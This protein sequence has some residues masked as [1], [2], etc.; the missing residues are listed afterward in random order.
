MKK[1]KRKPN[2]SMVIDV[3]CLGLVLFAFLYDFYEKAKVEKDNG[4]QWAGLI[5]SLILTV[6]TI[7]SIVFSLGKETY[8]GI[9]ISKYNR[10]R[11]KGYF[12]FFH[13]CIAVI[14]VVSLSGLFSGLMQGWL[15]REFLY[16]ALSLSVCSIIYSIVFIFEEVPLLIRN[17]NAIK[18]TIEHAYK[19]SAMSDNLDSK[20][21]NSILDTVLLNISLTEGIQTAYDMIAD[22]NDDKSAL[23]HLLELEFDEY[24]QINNAV[25]EN[26][27][28]LFEDSYF[29]D[30]KKGADL[31]S[32]GYKNIQD[33]ITNMRFENIIKNEK[34]N[35]IAYLAYELIELH[36]IAEITKQTEAERRGL[37]DIIGYE[38]VL[39]KPLLS[40]IVYACALTCKEGKTWFV[41]Y[42][43]MNNHLDMLLYREEGHYLGF[44]LAMMIVFYS[45]AYRGTEKDIYDLL[46]WDDDKKTYSI[47]SGVA[48]YLDDRELDE[49]ELLEKIYYLFN[50]VPPQVFIPDFGVCGYTSTN[51]FSFDVIINYWLEIIFRHSFYHWSKDDV[52]TSLEKYDS[53]LQENIYHVLKETW[54]NDNKLADSIPAYFIFSIC[55]VNFEIKQTPGNKGLINDL[56]A[57]TDKISKEKDKEIAQEPEKPSNITDALSYLKNGFKNK[58]ASVMVQDDS[59]S[60][61]KRHSISITGYCPKQ[62]YSIYFDLLFDRISDDIVAEINKEIKKAVSPIKIENIVS[63]DKGTLNRIKKFEPEFT[64]SPYE[65]IPIKDGLKNEVKTYSNGLLFVT[66]WKEDGIRLK[67]ELTQASIKELTDSEAEQF[68]RDHYQTYPNGFY[69]YVNN[70]YNYYVTMDELKEKIKKQYW[71]S[72]LSY[73]WNVIVNKENCLRFEKKQ[74]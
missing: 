61:K 41:K 16:T 52:L 58:M 9:T 57:F 63:Y 33:V 5:T 35:D 54:L 47:R 8:Y 48:A 69:R 17:E 62:D 29:I 66:F 49:F 34:G 68:I 51:E 18:R 27:S 21:D 7:V 20:R 46:D 1:Q 36:E 64:T 14:I 28:L 74:A 43:L 70:G 10:I 13:K 31:I 73:R 4:F 44:F 60:L 23:E 40:L 59:M 26:Q 24:K 71:L 12:D 42:L 39:S 50:L 30:G 19:N 15:K 55:R 72:S 2:Y 32:S 3:F 56:V 38:R 6:L 37:N 65:L 53:D 25:K 11:G 22:E 67:V 45:R